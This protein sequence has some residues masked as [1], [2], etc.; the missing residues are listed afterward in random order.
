VPHAAS[1]Y[2]F[3]FSVTDV[4]G[5]TSFP[6][7]FEVPVVP[8][9]NPAAGPPQVR[10]AALGGAAT[11]I[12]RAGARTAAPAATTR[13]V[14][15]AATASAAA[16][17]VTLVGTV[18]QPVE[19]SAGESRSRNGGDLTFQWRQRSGTPTAWLADGAGNFQFTPAVEDAYEFELTVTDAT[20]PAP[21]RRWARRA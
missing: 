14:A 4:D 8:A 16:S 9:G 18:G 10:L 20:A 3:E 1:T 5:L 7:Y 15:P 21:W 11:G 2:G 19:I 13:T 6:Q 17:E 12:A